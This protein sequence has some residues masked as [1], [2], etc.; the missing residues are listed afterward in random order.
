MKIWAVVPVKPVAVSKSRLAGVLAPEQ[1]TQLVISMLEHTLSVLAGWPALTGVLLVSADL[2]IW[3][4]GERYGVDVLR[5]ADAPGLNRSLERARDQVLQQG[6]EALLVVPADLPLLSRDNL[7]EIMA[8][9]PSAPGVVIAA[10]QLGSGTNTLLLSPAD[11]IPFQ[12]GSGSLAKHT[13]VAQQAGAAL[14][15]IDSP[16]LGFDIDRP[17]DLERLKSLGIFP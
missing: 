13:Q 11:V 2:H 16:A 9:A 15:R 14:V 3:L 4:I 17:Q 5:E 7:N 6:A 10:D 12:F 1:R 8:A